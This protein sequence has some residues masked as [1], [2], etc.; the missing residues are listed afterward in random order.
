RPGHRAG[1]GGAACRRARVRAAPTGR[2]GAGRRVC[3][4]AD[5][6]PARRYPLVLPLHPMVLR[7]NDAGGA[8]AGPAL[9]FIAA[10]AVMTHVAPFSDVRITDL[11]IYQSDANLL[12]GGATPY[13]TAF[14]F[15]YPPL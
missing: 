8:W 7:T 3:R 1:P 10:W 2:G 14:P 15:E 9:A 12:A 11:F 13:S 4:R 6:P 5:R